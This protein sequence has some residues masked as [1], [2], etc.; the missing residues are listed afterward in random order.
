MKSINIETMLGLSKP[1]GFNF[2]GREQDWAIEFADYTRVSDFINFMDQRHLSEE[3]RYAVLSLILAS[4]DECLNNGLDADRALWNN[5]AGLLD[6]DK[7]IVSDLLDYWAQYEEK[8]QE[9]L[10]AIT[11]LIREYLHRYK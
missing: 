7:E 4:Y 6:K 8:N 11:S 5:I 9:D 2:T 10:F 1:L 3:E